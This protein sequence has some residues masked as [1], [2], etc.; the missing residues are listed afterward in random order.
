MVI[1]LA[2]PALYLTLGAFTAQGTMTNN[3]QNFNTIVS[4]LQTLLQLFQAVFLEVQYSS[5]TA[6]TRLGVAIGQKLL[7]PSAGDFM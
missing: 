3:L 7:L 6:L 2:C 4:V 1:D 5:S